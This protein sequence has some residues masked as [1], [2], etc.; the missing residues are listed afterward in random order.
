MSVTKWCAL[1]AL[2]VAFVSSSAVAAPKKAQS[3]KPAVQKPADS[4]DVDSL[5]DAK[6][7]APKPDTKKTK[8][9]VPAAVAAAPDDT[10]TKPRAQADEETPARVEPSSHPPPAQSAE[11][12]SEPKAEPS[13][14]EPDAS[15]PKPEKPE[16]KQTADS[17]AVNAPVIDEAS[18][19]GG[20]LVV[21]P[22][23]LLS[24]GVKA[25]FEKT[26]PHNDVK[27]N[28]VSTFALGRIGIRARWL[29]FVYAES[30]F[31][32]S[33]GVGLHGTSAYE[34]Q[35][36][37]QV[38]QQL[39]RLS[40]GG[41]RVE[42]GR[43]IDE[44]SVDFVSAHVAESFLQDTAVR[45]PLLFTGFNLGNGVRASYEIVPGLRAALT[46]NAGNPVS[47]TDSLL[48][49]GGYPPHERFYT[50]PYV[51]VGQSANNFPDDTFHSMI[52]TPSVLLDTQYVDA[53]VAVQ[54]FDI[55]PNMASNT[56]DDIRGYNMRGTVRAKLLDRTI[57]P[58]A[59]AAYTRNDT[60]VQTNVALR[61]KERYQAVNVGGGIDA[62]LMRRFHCSYD[63]ADGFGI[64]YQQ[65][66]Y[67]I[68]NGLV[69]TERFFNLG[70]TYWLA[71]NLSL[72]ARFAMWMSEAEQAIGALGLSYGQKRPNIETTG[73]RSAIVALRFVMP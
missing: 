56:N 51:A 69:T 35:A 5:P 62:N 25:D 43:I 46:F 54:G 34:G 48:V 55:D 17:L 7:E 39:I 37:M 12:K 6:P 14:S 11:P 13:A 40:K 15:E 60:L 24:G 73:E 1:G 18:P 31:M 58:F 44:A 70:A 38:R 45:N 20:K 32:A 52:V 42:V 29:D 57:V 49:G 2:S 47:T 27:D 16:T 61:S 59:S 64:Q 65:V 21:R 22:Y 9:P 23:V 19:D 66:Q 68:G 41:L 36:A 67:Q 3:S 8:P 33:G 4:I 63:C 28:R 53:H 71:P 30:E 50:Q 72:G 10:K 26:K